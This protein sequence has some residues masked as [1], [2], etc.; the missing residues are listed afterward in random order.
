[1]ADL[2]VRQDVSNIYGNNDGEVMP[3]FVR[4]TSKSRDYQNK[5]SEVSFDEAVSK[6]SGVHNCT[7]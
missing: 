4:Y 5:N 2:E 7:K 6:L 1:M 3:L